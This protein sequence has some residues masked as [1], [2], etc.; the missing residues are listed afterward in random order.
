[1]YI[2]IDLNMYIIHAYLHVNMCVRVV[3]LNILK[4]Y[5]IHMNRKRKKFQ[6]F[7]FTFKKKTNKLIQ[8]GKDFSKSNKDSQV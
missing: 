8:S 7:S 1:M 2:N 3:D 5:H 4:V 6:R